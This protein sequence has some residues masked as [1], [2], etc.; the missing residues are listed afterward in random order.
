MLDEYR[1]VPLPIN[2]LKYQSVREQSFSEIILQAVYRARGLSNRLD[3]AFFEEWYQN[4]GTWDQRDELTKEV[5]K[6]EGV[7]NANQYSWEDV[8]QYRTPLISS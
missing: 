6:D 5:L 7:P 4:Q 8:Q 3:V 1:L 2:L